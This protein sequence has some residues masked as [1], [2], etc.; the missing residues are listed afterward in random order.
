MYEPKPIDTSMVELP[1][2]LEVL[3]EI[4][5]ESTHDHW[6]LQRLADGWT[7]GPKRDDTQ[8]TNPCMVPYA[9]LSESD[10]EYDRRTAMETLKAINA[11]GYIITKV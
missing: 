6:S 11:L 4:L 9:E 7:Y 3:T 1:E 2:E 5:A 8:K 10:K